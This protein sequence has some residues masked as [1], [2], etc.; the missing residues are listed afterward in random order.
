MIS[1]VLAIGCNCG[2]RKKNVSDAIRWISAVAEIV[3]KSTIYSSPDIKG[4]GHEY[5]NAVVKADF[6]GTPE[7]FNNFIKSY[8]ISVGRDSSCRE[9]GLVPIDIDIVMIDGEVTRPKDFRAEYFVKGYA[10]CLLQK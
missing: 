10:E 3:S 8:E 6:E 5:L 9:R 7:E 4:T 2:D 1:T